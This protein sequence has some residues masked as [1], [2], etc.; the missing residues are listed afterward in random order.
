MFRR[1]G[2]VWTIAYAG[3]RIQ[4]R[5]VK[6]LRYLARLLAQPGREIHVSDLAADGTGGEAVPVSGSGGK[7]I[8]AEAKRAYQQHLAEPEAEVAE[9][10]EWNE[11]E[12][13]ARPS[14][15]RRPD[16]SARRRLRPRRPRPHDGRPDRADP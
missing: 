9:A 6:G 13:V 7:L 4:L 15:D 14:R 11:A 1:E 3:T 5:E 10:T 2:D 16:R 8:D 12:R